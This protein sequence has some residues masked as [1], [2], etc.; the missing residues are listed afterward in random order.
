MINKI[1]ENKKGLRYII[2]TINRI[3]VSNNS[4]GEI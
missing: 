4:R 1:A 3:R 2:N